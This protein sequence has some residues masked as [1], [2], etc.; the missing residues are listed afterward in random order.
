MNI[1]IVDIGP[2]SGG[3]PRAWQEIAD[4]LYEAHS[5]VGFS[6]LVNHGV[7]REVIRDLFDASERFH[8]LPLEQKMRLRYGANLRGFLPL[9]TSRLTAST[10]GAARRPN[11]SDSFVVLDELPDSLRPAWDDSTMGGAQIWPAQVDGFEQAA[12][13]YRNAMI[14]LGRSLVP[15]FASMLGLEHDGLAG[16]FVQ[17][18]TI[19]RLLHYPA[20]QSPEP[21]L[22]GSA[23]HTDYGCLTFVAQDDVGGLEV[24]AANGQWL[25]VPVVENSLVL[26]TGQV[27]AK[28]SAG[29]IKATPHRVVNSQTRDRYS[30]AFFFDCGLETPLNIGL[31]FQREPEQQDANATYG[32]HLEQILRTNYSFTVN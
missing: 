31:P 8:R 18:N 21:D 3:D 5:T 13:R 22:Y 27:M 9:K 6:V 14:Q 20:V 24:Q 2:L 7:D 30:I 15:T 12:R 10:L 16:Y 28:W 4:A 32:Q 26:N 29:R 19:L 25:A 17:P 11:H 1:P 23:P